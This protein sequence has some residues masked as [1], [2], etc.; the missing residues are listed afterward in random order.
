MKSIFVQASLGLTLAI[1][2]TKA[3]A[4]IQRLPAAPAVIFDT[5]IGPDYDDV[6]AITLLQILINKLLMQTPRSRVRAPGSR[7]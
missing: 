5:D 1:F 2:L 7:H 4:Q 6:G 3:N